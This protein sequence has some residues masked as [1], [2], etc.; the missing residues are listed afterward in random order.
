MTAVADQ[1]QAAAGVLA[2]QLDTSLFGD[3]ASH[4]GKSPAKR[5]RRSK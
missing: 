3:Q 5:G 1:L 4:G 2:D